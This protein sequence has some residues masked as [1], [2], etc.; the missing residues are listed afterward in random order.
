MTVTNAQLKQIMN[1]ELSTTASPPTK[2][3]HHFYVRTL[4]VKTQDLKSLL[5]H[6]RQ[7]DTHFTELKEWE[8]EIQ[9]SEACG[10]Q[11]L[12]VRKW[13]FCKGPERTI[14][15]HIEDLKKWSSGIF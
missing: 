15:R 9:A 12:T 5:G 7:G 1:M 11:I 8:R 13:G 2:E 10:V 14:D 6:F 3:G 4:T